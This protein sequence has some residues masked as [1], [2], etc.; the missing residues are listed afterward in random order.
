[1]SGE[2]RRAVACN[3]CTRCCH[4]DTIILHP[5]EGDVITAYET[6]RVVNP[7]TG[8]PAF[9]LQQ[10]PDGACI[11]LAPAKEG[12]PGGCTIHDRA[13]HICRTFDCGRIVSAFGAARLKR[14]VEAGTF[15]AAV[16][17]A[18]RMQLKNRRAQAHAAAQEGSAA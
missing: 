18:G 12:Q 1:M 3:G 10:K 4:D 7:V 5:E 15:S 8:K 14:L 2:T 17:A 9:A 11:Y 6:R 13:P 16:V